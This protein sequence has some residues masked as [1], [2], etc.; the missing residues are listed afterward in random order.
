[1]WN[2]CALPKLRE[3]LKYP[4]LLKAG[5]MLL[6]K[7]H[8]RQPSWKDW[9]LAKERSPSALGEH[10]T[11]VHCRASLQVVIRVLGRSQGNCR[12]LA[13][14]CLK[15]SRAQ[16]PIQQKVLF[17]SF[18]PS[19]MPSE[20]GHSAMELTRWYS[21]SKDC[22]LCSWVAKMKTGLWVNLH[23]WHSSSILVP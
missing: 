15:S 7:D 14:E 19:L 13:S 11:F 3:N 21:F 9:S 8:V 2:W 1:M 23:Y 12:H 16:E 22:N 6:Y 5:P 20:D 17:S 18:E 4:L 10:S